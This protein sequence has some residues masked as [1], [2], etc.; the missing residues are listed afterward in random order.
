MRLL[1]ELPAQPSY[2]RPLASHPAMAEALWATI[3]ELRMA[4]VRPD[5][6]IRIRIEKQAVFEMGADC[7]RLTRET[8][9][10]T[11]LAG[12]ERVTYE[13]NLN[14]SRHLVV[15]SAA[16]YCITWSEGPSV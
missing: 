7:P 16:P 13:I 5:Q 6:K 3:R 15:P 4:G 2:F 11:G 1:L 8:I 9:V 14:C 12:V 10:P